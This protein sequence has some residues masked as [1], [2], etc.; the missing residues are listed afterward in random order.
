MT[1]NDLASD[2]RAAWCLGLPAL[3][4]AAVLAHHPT[5]HMAHDAPADQLV[6]AMS[7]IAAR[8]AAFHALVL[9]ML[10]TQA[11]G[12]WSFV[13]KLGLDQLV[14]RAGVHF[15]GIAT[16]LLFVAGTVDGFA[17]PLMNQGCGAE[18]MRCASAATT[19]FSIGFALIQSF[20]TVGLGMQALG[21]AFLSIA[22]ASHRR[23]H[24]RGKARLAGL[25]AIPIALVPL[26]LLLASGATIGPARLVLLILPGCVCSLG[27]AVLL[28]TG[29]LAENRSG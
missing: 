26:A 18:P 13:D 28:W 15:Y 27:A 19:V 7:A 11:I 5:L 12:L 22:L 3:L 4:F 8:N 29:A 24:R 1:T 23:S 16:V 14:V 6:A 10:S 20:T 17:V 21:L 2:R 25:L 9:L